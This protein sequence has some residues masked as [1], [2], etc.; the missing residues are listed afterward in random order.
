[1]VVHAGVDGYSRTIGYMSCADNNR[2][3]TV[4]DGFRQ[5]VVEYG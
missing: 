1:M 2:A 4:F 3:S 5:A